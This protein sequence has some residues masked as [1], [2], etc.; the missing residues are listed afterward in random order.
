MSHPPTWHPKSGWLA[1]TC[2]ISRNTPSSVT[3]V[4]FKVV[5]SLIPDVSVL[6]L[7]IRPSSSLTG[8]SYKYVKIPWYV[9]SYFEGHSCEAVGALGVS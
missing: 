9:P 2:V 8:I 6:Y 7:M 1:V 4:H 3:L 5:D